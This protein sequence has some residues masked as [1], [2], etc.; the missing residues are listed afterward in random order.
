MCEDKKALKERLGAIMKSKKHGRLA[1]IL[2]AVLIVAAILTACALGAG[3]A[4]S[5]V[6][7]AALL[8][9]TREE[10]YD[11]IG[12]P[13]ETINEVDIFDIGGK[14]VHITYNE[15]NR[16]EQINYNG[17]VV[18]NTPTIFS[19]LTL[20]D[21]RALAAKGDALQYTDLP[22]LRPS[23]LSSTMGGYNPTLY[24]VEGGY[25]L[26]VNFTNTVSPE[27][28]IRSIQLE[29]IWENG[30]SGIDIRYSDGGFHRHRTLT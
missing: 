19:I 26:L 17:E 25:R 1:V 10:V 30:G 3:R 13:K 29:S 11:R 23:M 8:G 15:N 24:S 28:G 20:D 5:S 12:N 27:S 7:F 14:T 4:D 21:V 9:A 2:S 6:E 18:V 22:N 16:V